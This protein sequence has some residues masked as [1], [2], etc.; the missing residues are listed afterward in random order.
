MQHCWFDWAKRTKILKQ[1]IDLSGGKMHMKIFYA[2]MLVLCS[3]PLNAES[4]QNEY[5]QKV[6]NSVG[7][8]VVDAKIGSSC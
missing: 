2:L 8:A 1:G 5:A 6:A 7:L 4:L 3:S